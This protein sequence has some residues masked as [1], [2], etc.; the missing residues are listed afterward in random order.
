M[1]LVCLCGGQMWNVIAELRGVE[2]PEKLVLVGNHRDAW[3][4]GAGDPNSGAYTR[5]RM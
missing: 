5:L 2:E 3:I 4:F 1:K